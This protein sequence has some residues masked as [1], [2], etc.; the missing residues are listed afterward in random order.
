[1]SNGVILHLITSHHIVL[2]G[3]WSGKEPHEKLKSLREG[4]EGL[5]VWM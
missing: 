1:M 2:H 4:E 3:A 5:K